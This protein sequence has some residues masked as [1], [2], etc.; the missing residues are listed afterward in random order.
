ML[1]TRSTTVPWRKQSLPYFF[2]FRRTKALTIFYINASRT[3]QLVSRFMGRFP[4]QVAVLHSQLTVKERLIQFE[5]IRR[6]ISRIAIG[7]RSAIFA[8]VDKLGL[9]IVDEEHETSYKQ[10]EKFCYQAR[11]VNQQQIHCLRQSRKC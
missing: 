8:P 10:D 3:G 2:L 7:A 1:P 11:D 6:S 4:G 5:K 9:I